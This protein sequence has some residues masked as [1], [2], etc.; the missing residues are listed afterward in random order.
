LLTGKGPQS[1]IFNNFLKFSFSTKPEEKLVDEKELFGPEKMEEARKSI[2]EK[3]KQISK[4]E[5]EGTNIK[6]DP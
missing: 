6:H 5:N 2:K 1:R 4:E 3:L